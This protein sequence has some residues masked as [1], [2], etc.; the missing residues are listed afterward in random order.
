MTVAS[1]ACA[2][3]ACSPRVQGDGGL[4]GEELLLGEEQPRDGHNSGLGAQDAGL[5]HHPERVIEIAQVE[6]QQHLG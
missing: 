4:R 6:V 3:L 1:G 2:V 5:G